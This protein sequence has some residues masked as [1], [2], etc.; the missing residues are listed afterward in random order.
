MHPRAAVALF[1][2]A[3][4]FESLS[5]K[6]Q[7]AI[8]DLRQKGALTEQDLDAAMRE[9]RLA[10]LEADVNFRVVKTFV[11]AVRERALGADVLK[12][13]TPGQMV[14]KIVDEELTA[15]LGGTGAALELA[16]KTPTVILLCGLQGSGKTTLAGKLARMLKKQG[17]KPALVACDL[18]RPAAIEQL[19]TLGRQVDVP[20]FERGAQADPVDVAGWGVEQAT[21]QARDVVIVDTAGRL[22]IDSELMDELARVRKRVSPHEVLLVLDSMTGQEA[23]AVAEQFADSIDITGIVMTKLDGDAR[24]G[25]ALSVRAVTGKPIK[26]ISV[27][28][29]LDALEEFHPDRMASRILGMGDVLSLIERAEEHISKDEAKELER[30]MRKSE[31]TLEDMLDQLRQVRKMGSLKSILGLLPGIGKQ[32]KG[33]DVDERQ[34]DRVEA[35][36][37]SMTIKERRNPQVIDGSRRRRIAG[38]SGTSVQQVNQLLQQHK[39]MKKLMKQVASG[40]MPSMSPQMGASATRARPKKKRR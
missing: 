12:S 20:V 15:L 33:M 2:R 4:V 40:K 30:K 39:Q 34:I 11:A 5:D 37:L 38:G 9:I 27:G 26:L 6:L 10:L 24:G 13:L 21:A 17:R 14:V 3:I 35:M 28:E 16:A 32:I 19:L 31:F 23:V 22:Q 1:S 7:S 36:I 8:G 18:Q 29:K 25:A